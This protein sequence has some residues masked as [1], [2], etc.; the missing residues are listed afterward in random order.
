M[1]EKILRFDASYMGFPEEIHLR[2]LTDGDRMMRVAEE[3]QRAKVEAAAR[4]ISPRFYQMA[5]M[6]EACWVSPKP[7]G[8]GIEFFIALG[9]R[10]GDLFN[11]LLLAMSI[12]QNRD[13]ADATGDSPAEREAAQ[14][15]IDE[16]KSHILNLAEMQAS[17]TEGLA[18]FF[19]WDAATVN[20][21]PPVSTS[22]TSTPGNSAT[23]DSPLPVGS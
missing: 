18:D 11:S 9:K 10:Y 5:V 15:R 23:L 13:G 21:S 7:K 20:S 17:D 3:T 8:R 22:V 19:E 12:A 14:S 1:A 16:V 4:S 6:L 2:L